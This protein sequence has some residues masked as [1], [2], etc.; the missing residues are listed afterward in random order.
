M[1][2]DEN[3]CISKSRC[4]QLLTK[5]EFSGRFDISFVESRFDLFNNELLF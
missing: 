3:F 1:A 4:P 2:G 5:T